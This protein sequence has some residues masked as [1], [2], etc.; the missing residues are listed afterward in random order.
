MIIKVQSIMKMD[1]DLLFY[2]IG[3]TES[4]HFI[5]RPLV[6]FLPE[7]YKEKERWEDGSYPM[8]LFLLGFLPLGRHVVKIR[9]DEEKKEMK[10]LGG[11]KL[12]PVWHHLIRVEKAGKNHAKYTDIILIKAGWKT[13]FIALFAE[14]FYRYRQYRWRKR[15]ER[16]FRKGKK[17]RDRQ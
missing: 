4:F 16:K 9:I 10:D 2:E 6:T 3:K 1:A 12:V 11:G 15:I 17:R 5:T 13:V 8:K 7:G 14:V